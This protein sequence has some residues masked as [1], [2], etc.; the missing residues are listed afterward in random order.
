MSDFDKQVGRNLRGVELEETGR[1]DEAI[2]HSRRHVAAPLRVQAMAGHSSFDT[3]LG[4]YHEVER[5]SALAEDL[6]SCETRQNN[7]TQETNMTIEYWKWV[8]T[9]LVEDA[10]DKWREA[11]DRYR[12]LDEA[13]PVEEHGA[14]CTKCGRE[15]KVLFFNPEIKTDA[16][17]RAAARR[18]I[19]D[20][21]HRIEKDTE[22]RCGDHN[23]TWAL[24]P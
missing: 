18:L 14:I 8:D 4:Y 3:T 15:A 21:R 23:L 2:T 7:Q 5:T 24:M 6:I 20:A 12:P 9:D 19:E 10:A 1:V 11:R 17:M 16:E 13:G 22:N